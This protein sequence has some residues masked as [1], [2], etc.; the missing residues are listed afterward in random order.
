MKER[1]MPFS[2]KK[3]L[4]KMLGGDDAKRMLGKEIK[5]RSMRVTIFERA[6]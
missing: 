2:E 1:T 3:A 4:V 6:H 5:A